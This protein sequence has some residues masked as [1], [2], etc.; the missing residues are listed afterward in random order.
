MV[1]SEGDL[2]QAECMTLYDLTNG[3]CVSK[4]MFELENI[5]YGILGDIQI[6]KNRSY[7]NLNMT[8]NLKVVFAFTEYS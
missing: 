6:W 3:A 5:I 1:L 8:T 7:S 4:K 2:K